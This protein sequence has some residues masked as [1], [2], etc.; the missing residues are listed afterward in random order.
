MKRNYTQEDIN[1]EINRDGVGYIDKLIC[2]KLLEKLK[3]D[4]VSSITSKYFEDFLDSKRAEEIRRI[5]ARFRSRFEVEE[6]SAILNEHQKYLWAC[7]DEEV[8]RQGVIDGKASQVLSQSGLIITLSTLG[9]PSIL[10][11]FTENG[12]F[13]GSGLALIFEVSSLLVIALAFIGFILAVVYAGMMLHPKKFMRPD[14]QMTLIEDNWD[15][16]KFKIS[17]QDEIIHSIV[18]NNKL[19]GKKARQLKRSNRLF[20][21]SLL[22][23]LFSILLIYGCL[24]F[25]AIYPSQ[26]T[27]FS[28]GEIQR[29]GKLVSNL[30]F[31]IKDFN[32]GQ[33]SQDDSLK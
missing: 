8:R 13:F 22:G 6:S 7:F 17:E 9:I 2:E 19:N 18:A 10:R 20:R 15:I 25:R 26:K 33:K 1:R 21:F 3:T 29:F 32:E 14:Y 31:N 28:T 24:T 12:G 4:I 5:R 11:A 27:V 16:A 23:F 30:E